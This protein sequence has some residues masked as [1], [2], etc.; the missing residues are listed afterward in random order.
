M[1]PILLFAFI[2]LSS[3][4]SF[5]QDSSKFKLYD[6]SANAEK[7]VKEAIKTAKKYNRHVLVQI[8]GNWCIWCRRF[9]KLVTEND[10][11][12]SL[13]DTNFVVVHL[14][15][16]PENRNY[17]MLAALGYPQRFGFPVFVI[18]DAKG[19]RLHTQNSGYLE[20]GKGHSKAKVEEFLK[21]WSPQA[22]NPKNYKE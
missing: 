22:L 7:Q 9:H 4:N 3:V 13:I 14:N 5:A 15:Y 2:I 20:E 1:K 17:K 18:L 19:N 12:R 10:T 16:S 11:L 8:G 21:H 6:P